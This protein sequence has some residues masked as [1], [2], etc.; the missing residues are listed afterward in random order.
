MD[1]AE[2]RGIH[3]WI[4]QAHEETVK[5]SKNTNFCEG[6]E[7]RTSGM[8]CAYEGSV[9]WF[10]RCSL[11]VARVASLV[12]LSCVLGPVA[13]VSDEAV[14]AGED[15]ALSAGSASLR[16]V[17]VLTQSVPGAM[18]A[19][20]ELR[21]DTDERIEV[22]DVALNVGGATLPLTSMMLLGGEEKGIAPGALALIVDDAQV[23]AKVEAI[24]CEQPVAT[25]QASLGSAHAAREDV[26]VSTLTLQSVRHCLPV[27]KA[28]GLS[29][30]LASSKVISVSRDSRQLDEFRVPDS[31]APQG[32]SLERSELREAVVSALGS[33]PGAR[34]FVTWEPAGRGVSELAAHHSSAWRIGTDAASGAR[35]GV[36]GPNPL[37]EPLVSV[38]EKAKRYIGGAFYQLNDETVVDALAAARQRGVDVQIATDAE[39]LAHRN[40]AAGLRKLTSAGVRVVGD[41]GSTGNN[42]SSLAHNK[43]MV[44]DDDWVWTGS[45]NPVKPEAIR[46]HT[47]NAVLLRSKELAALHREEMDLMMSGKFGTSKRDAGRVGADAFVSGALT[48]VRFSPGLTSA[49]LK[50][51]ADEF[52]RTKDPVQACR[53]ATAA[54]K[55]IL[56]A[57]YQSTQPCGGP[58]DVLYAEVARATSS[59]YFAHFSLALDGL[60]DILK[61]RAREGV[62]VKG[63]VDATI[64]SRAETLAIARAG[65]SVKYTP[66]SDPSCPPYVKPRSACPTNPNKVWLHHKFVIIDYG[67]DHPVVVTGSHNMSDGAEE[68]NDESLVVIRDRAI[69]ESYYRT[70]REMYVHPQALDVG[71]VSPEVPALAI[72]KV[73]P[74]ADPGRSQVVEIMNL[75][76]TPVRLNDL[77]V[78]NRREPPL[79]IR[80]A[81]SLAPGDTR[82]IVI[83]TDTASFRSTERAFLAPGTSLVVATKENHWVATYDAYTSA[84]TT[85]SASLPAQMRVASWAVQGIDTATLDKTMLSLSGKN[86]SANQQVPQWNPRGTY[87][88]WGDGVRVTRAGTLLMLTGSATWKPSE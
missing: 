22:S 40:Y 12:G 78:W 86:T 4:L 1:D 36:V 21:N 79:A 63:V 67:T 35:R 10:L 51:R 82:R 41:V 9:K 85:P 28:Q 66:N 11:R 65:G 58:L 42:R 23:A 81:G 53:V 75:D 52:A 57:R 31:P 55:P 70:F 32:V 37:A 33:T 76:T 62:E 64:S 20:I 24:A 16:I 49:Q 30:A 18:G 83:G 27:M 43:F 14:E 80:G 5:S 45:Y 44:V 84:L 8:L 50:A 74:S 73:E 19:F 71:T 39:F 68:Q 17:E 87:S 48:T 26:L 13:C 2:E 46:V 54:G 56:E 60:V 3:G 15:S 69:A 7:R 61:E 72:T 59:L 6:E 88:D 77:R 47:D 38:I 29:G 25:T 34:N